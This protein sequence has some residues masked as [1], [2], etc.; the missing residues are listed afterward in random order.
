MRYEFIK[1]QKKAFPIALL[2]RFMEVSRSGYYDYQQRQA[3]WVEPSQ[4]QALVHRVKVIDEQT[5]GSYGSRRMAKQLQSEG[6][7]VGRY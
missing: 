3:Q 7:P 4:K 5:G 1:E 6:Y 2:C